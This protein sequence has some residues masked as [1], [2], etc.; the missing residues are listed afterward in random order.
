MPQ[1]YMRACPRSIGANSSLRPVIE[2][3]MRR[4]TSALPQPRGRGQTVAHQ[5]LRHRGKDQGELR[6][7]VPS[8]ER[9]PQRHEERLALAPG[10]RL[11]PVGER[12]EV[13]AG[14]AIACEG[15]LEECR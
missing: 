13:A 1:T 14:L 4:P 3:W 8:R 15:R 9:E 5:R 12:R 11:E 2:L 6:P 10:A 7:V